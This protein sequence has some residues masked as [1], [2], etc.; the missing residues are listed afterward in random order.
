VDRTTEQGAAQD[1]ASLCIR[2]E[3]DLAGLADDAVCPECGLDV[4]RSRE[5][6]RLLRGADVPWLQTL[7][8][9]LQDL[10]WAMSLA[11]AA[12]I[13]GIVLVIVVLLLGLAFDV[14]RVFGFFG[15]PVFLLM[16]AAAVLGLFLHI[17]GCVR[18]SGSTHR[19]YDPGWSSRHAVRYGGCIFPFLAVAVGFTHS[20]PQVVLPPEMRNTIAAAMQLSALGF[21]FGL[22]RTLHHLERH[23][24]SWGE[25]VRRRQRNVRKNLYGVVILVAFGWW[26]ASRM[27]GPSGS[28]GLY[29]F[30][31]AYMFMTSAVART[32][33][34]VAAEVAIATAR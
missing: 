4:A 15:W 16:M 12:F 31:L 34:E 5:R 6:S 8:R 19:D 26:L 9:G 14:E 2:C 24:P 23:L 18:I 1:V 11:V 17:R 13:G 22:A 30:S 20:D 27:P 32:R 29:W 10:E 21:F 3:Y 33:R 28:G 25:T 7:G